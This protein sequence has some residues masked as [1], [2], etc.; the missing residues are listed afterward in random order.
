MAKVTPKPAGKGTPPHT[1]RWAILTSRSKS[2][3]FP[4]TS[5]CRPAFNIVFKTYAVT[6]GKQMSAVLPEAF[7]AL[8]AA[9]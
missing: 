8:T 4:L 3:T 2:R 5:R 1:P 7:A 9:D 6:Q